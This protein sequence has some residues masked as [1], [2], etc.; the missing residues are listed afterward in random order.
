MNPDI[1]SVTKLKDCFIILEKSCATEVSESRLKVSNF[2]PSL[3]LPIK[4]VYNFQYVCKLSFL[5][6]PK[7]FHQYKNFQRMKD[8]KICQFI[9]ILVI[10]SKKECQSYY[11]LSQIAKIMFLPKNTDRNLLD[12]IF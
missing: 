11:I 5:S 12:S 3:H 4:C 9:D 2:A 1:L 7:L 6:N 10:P 8:S